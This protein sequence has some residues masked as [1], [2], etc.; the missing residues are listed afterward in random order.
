MATVKTKTEKPVAAAKE[1]TSAKKTVAAKKPATKAASPRKKAAGV[2]ANNQ[3][4]Y[5]AIQHAAY[6]I[7]EKDGFVK[8][9]ISYWLEAEAQAKAP[10]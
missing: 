7:A 2:T 9:A 5:E 6:L 4:S 1:A 10:Q 8:D 3:V